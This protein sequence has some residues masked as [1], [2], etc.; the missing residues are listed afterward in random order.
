MTHTRLPKTLPE[1]FKFVPKPGASPL[2]KA[3]T[4]QKKA[5]ALRDEER[6][7]EKKGERDPAAPHLQ[8]LE[9]MRALEALMAEMDEKVKREYLG[10]F[11]RDDI[12]PHEVLG[13]MIASLPVP[14]L[15]LIFKDERIGKLNVLLNRPGR[16]VRQVI[17]TN[18]RLTDLGITYGDFIAKKRDLKFNL[19][20]QSY[21]SGQALGLYFTIIQAASDPK[22]RKRD[23]W[24]QDDEVLELANGI[25]REVATH[26]IEDMQ[27]RHD[28]FYDVGNR[29]QVAMNERRG[30]R[31]V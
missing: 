7:N 19:G 15:E 9:R 26:I 25:L 8:F 2:A 28:N 14:R 24:V 18:E 12:G 21:K 22:V 6:A 11:N 20:L 13:H 1:S 30:A 5:E 27:K 17:E 29:K 23:N 10:R 3:R 4:H 16:K 31:K